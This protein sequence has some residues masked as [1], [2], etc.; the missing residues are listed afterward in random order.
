MSDGQWFR[1]TYPPC[2]SSISERQKVR[3]YQ[4]LQYNS[5]Y[6]NKKFTKAQR[7]RYAASNNGSVTNKTKSCTGYNPPNCSDVPGKT[8]D[9]FV[10]TDIINHEPIIKTN[11]TIPGSGPTYF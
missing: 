1:F 3:K 10:T 4:T 8:W 2:P 6:N 7:Y 5:V 11:S 9:L